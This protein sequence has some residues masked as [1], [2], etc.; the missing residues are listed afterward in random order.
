MCERGSVGAGDVLQEMGYDRSG[1]GAGVFLLDVGPA[2][3][4]RRMRADGAR[5]YGFWN[6]A[7]EALG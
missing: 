5:V 3:G 2:V 1:E 4:G 7:E 6:G